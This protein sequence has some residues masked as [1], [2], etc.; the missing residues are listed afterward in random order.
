[1]D[2]LSSKIIDRGNVSFVQ[3]PHRALKVGL[4][5]QSHRP[6]TASTSNRLSHT[7]L[8]LFQ[9]KSRRAGAVASNC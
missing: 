7:H 4:A 3:F 5:R 1:M 2:E 8:F 6:A 9:G